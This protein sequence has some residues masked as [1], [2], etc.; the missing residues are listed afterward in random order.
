M[1]GLLRFF[2]RIWATVFCCFGMWIYA[3]ILRFRHR[4]NPRAS[5]L[6]ISRAMSQW[7]Y[8]L[9][10]IF[11]MKIRITGTPPKAPFFLVSNH[12]SYTDILLLCA[13]CP[14][15]F[16]SKAEVARWPG[17]GPL[18]R[19]ANTLFIDRE[20]RRDVHRMNQLIAD[21]VRDG[22]GV[23]FFP[24]GTT[25]D[26]T[27][28]IP[29]KPSLL[30]PAIEHKIPVHV[31]AI[32][33]ET[34]PG[35]PPPEDLVAWFGVGANIGGHA[36]KLLQVRSFTA[37]VHFAEATCQAEDRKTLARITHAAVSGLHTTLRNQ[38]RH[39]P[40]PA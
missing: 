12:L 34:L 1:I 29:F 8:A 18:T 10:W 15:W 11:G 3:H 5:Y 24:E 16:I 37:F 9:A 40:N 7:G 26:G 31:A 13:T 19:V 35:C 28:V 30:Q 6:A 4:R 27:S 32:A 38:T 39:A 17:I 33:Y 2:I 20:T 21:L 23:S 14:G 25:T 22:G 36:F